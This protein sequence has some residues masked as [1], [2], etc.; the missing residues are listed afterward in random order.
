[1]PES[2]FLK[3]LDAGEA[4]R[5]EPLAF[6]IADGH[7]VTPGHSL[8][9]PKRPVRDFFQLTEPEWRAIRELIHLRASDLRV[10]DPSITGFNIG[11]NCGEAAGQ[12][13]MHCHVH[14]IPRRD[15][16]TPAPRGGVRGVIPDKQSY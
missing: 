1:M 13:V 16:D 14:L 11:M 4:L 12:T 7:P 9:C 2:P 15:G 8:I 5:E 10:E 3:A 6:V